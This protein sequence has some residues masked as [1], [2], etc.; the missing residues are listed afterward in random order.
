MSQSIKISDKN[1]IKV[2]ELADKEG[3][4]KKVIIDKALSNYFK[5]KKMIKK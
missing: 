4:F 5:S 3:R 2:K 1:Y